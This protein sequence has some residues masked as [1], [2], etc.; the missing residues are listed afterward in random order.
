[1]KQ[2]ILSALV[3][4]MAAFLITGCGMNATGASNE[5]DGLATDEQI[6]AV[7]EELGDDMNEL[8]FSIDGVVYQ[9]PMTMQTM[10]DA[11]WY[12]DSSVEKELK[13]LEGNTRTTGFVLRKNRSGEYG[14]TECSVVASNDSSYEKEI[15]ETNLYNLNFR[16]EKGAVLV[17]PQG[18][19]W[20][21]TFEEVC[22]AYKPGADYII[23]QDGVLTITFTNSS[24][25]G[26][27]V[28]W[29]DTQTR[30]L[31]ELKFY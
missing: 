9:Y 19:R 21:S 6:A 23:D 29:F 20:D 15:G 11:D 31:S 28:M 10:L 26:H 27:L 18:L 30:E 25:D 13:T 22:E 7:K 16:R 12:P 17:L 24:Y 2:K 8:K 3:V 14:I 5:S 4:F 1:M